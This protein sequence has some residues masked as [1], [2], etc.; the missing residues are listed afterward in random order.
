MLIIRG[1]W[2]RRLFGSLA[3]VA[4]AIAGRFTLSP[5][6]SVAIPQNITSSI[7]DKP[8]P[9]ID[10]RN[11]PLS[12]ALGFVDRYLGGKLRIDWRPLERRG[13]RRDS[14]ITLGVSGADVGWVLREIL[15]R[16]G[17]HEGFPVGMEVLSDDTILIADKE[18]IRAH[19]TEVSY[20]LRPLPR[21]H[22]RTGSITSVVRW[23]AGNRTGGV[24]H[25]PCT[26]N[27]DGW[28][29]V[30]LVP[31]EHALARGLINRQLSQSASLSLEWIERIDLP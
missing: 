25:E 31:V 12:E 4:I 29:S 23:I 11:T 30:L 19:I 8:M 14:P 18:I 24:V 26:V 5:R 3:A 21:G 22:D 27:D 7:L 10:F 17:E 1:K 9:A 28:L 20:D 6:A 13:V 15:V 16:V 2:R